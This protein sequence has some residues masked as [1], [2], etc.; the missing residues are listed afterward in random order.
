[1]S[2]CG[3]KIEEDR[4]AGINKRCWQKAFIDLCLVYLFCKIAS[5]V[6]LAVS[7]CLYLS[8]NKSILSNHL[9]DIDLEDQSIIQETLKE[10]FL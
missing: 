2:V 4:D 3:R 10:Y 1:M 7:V 5:S 9:T 6:C 8:L